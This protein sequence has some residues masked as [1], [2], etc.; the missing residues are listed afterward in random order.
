MKLEPRQI[1]ARRLAQARKMRGWSLRELE[2]QLHGV[3]THAALHKY[4]QGQ[5]LPGTDVLVP[6][7]S[8]LHQSADYFFRTPTVSLSQIEFRKRSSLGVRQE[9]VL[10]EKAAEF[11]ERYLEV[12]QLLGVD[13]AF[14]HPL[15]GVV[16]RKPEDIESAAL[17][18]RKAWNLGL[19][20]LSN[21]VEMLENHQI[22]VYDLDADARFDGF[23]GWADGIPV[24]VL[25]KNFPLVRK[26][27]TAL[28]ELAHLIL[29]FAKG[30]FD[31]KQIEKLCHAFAGAM[32]LPEDVFRQRFGGRRSSITINELSDIKAD[33][34][35]SIGAIMARARDLGLV[36]GALYKTF[37]IEIRKCGWHKHEPGD[38]IGLEH[39]N[40]FEQLIYRAVSTD[41]VSM[42]KA[43]TLAGQRLADFRASIQM[44]P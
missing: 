2:S 12:E 32:L 26:R 37:C 38:Y 17:K 25:N 30:Q 44:V 9:E 18:L 1:F 36:N 19:D 14:R 24:V 34:G 10:R 27:L 13:A 42:T 43:A 16:V 33:Y 39:S 11:F 15:K 21:V 29:T 3:V 31:S 5:M 20:A 6:L 40:R 28:H 8:A 41:A 4:E 35:I 23:S 7:A 22:K